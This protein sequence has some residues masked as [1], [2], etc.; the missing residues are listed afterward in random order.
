M[1]EFLFLTSFVFENFVISISKKF[2]K[3]Y[4]IF[5]VYFYKKL[6]LF[7]FVELI[8]SFNFLLGFFLYFP[9]CLFLC[10]SLRVN[11]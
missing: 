1:N 2:Q 10:N 8:F 9:L 5:F 3:D 7:V 11:S 6:I 4:E